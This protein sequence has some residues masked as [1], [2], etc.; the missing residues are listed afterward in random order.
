MSV[1]A[2]T[3]VT[4]AGRTVLQRVQSSGLG[5]VTI[6]KDTIREVG[7]ELV[8]DKV[9]QEPDFTFT[10][11]SL[12]VSCDIEALLHGK[13]GDGGGGGS[14]GASEND[15]DG[16]EY[17]W[18]TSEAI[19][20]A[21]PWKDHATGSAGH[22]AAGH[23]IPGFYP[24]SIAYRFGVTDNAQT[25]V[26]LAGGAFYYGEFAPV[27]EQQTVAGGTVTSSDPAIRY[28]KGGAAGTTFKSVFGV[29]SKGKMLIEG[30]DYNVAGG[31]AAPGSPVTLTFTARV[32]CRQRRHGAP[33]V[34]HVGLAGLPAA[35][36]TAP[37]L[38]LPGAVRGRQHLRLDLSRSALTAARHGRLAAASPTSQ[39]AELD[40]L[41]GRGRSS[42]SSATRSRSAARSTASTRTATSWSARATT[43]RSSSSCAT[44]R[45][46]TW[47][48]RSSASSTRTRSR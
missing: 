45:A 33:R 23:L 31:A 9:P 42:A 30:Y 21:S 1:H 47:T 6:P 38:V 19:N 24:T 22:V 25:T 3:I 7:N 17:P 5:N 18:E 39:T 8:V 26:E 32:R 44:S 28:R 12:D 48:M 37:T 40:G 11:E 13:R 16:T 20:V 35:A 10:L 29:I 41:G 46:S 34:L 43:R 14:D 15:P 4:V 36:F 27:E 2:G